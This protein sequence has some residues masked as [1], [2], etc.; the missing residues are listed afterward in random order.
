MKLKFA[1]LASI[2][3]A[4]ICSTFAPSAGA[5]DLLHWGP[6]AGTKPADFE[7][8]ASYQL[9]F[10]PDGASCQDLLVSAID[11]TRSQLR[12]QAYSFTSAPIAAAIKRAKD[13]G[14]DV[15]VILDKSQVS[16][17]YS[18]ATYLRNAGIDVAIDIKPAIAHNKVMIF[19]GKA[20]FTGSFNFTKAAQQRNAENGMLV[21]GDHALTKAYLSNWDKRYSVSSRF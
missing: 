1:V 9:C 6:A 8:G 18:G 2:V 13:R 20:V 15:R 3:V 21:R 10:V 19:D 17:K 16:Q 4:A 11:Q 5:L 12:V 7:D 14:V